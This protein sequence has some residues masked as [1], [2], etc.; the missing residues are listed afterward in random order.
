MDVF[1]LAWSDGG[2]LRGCEISRSL[3][4]SSALPARDFKICSESFLKP[5]LVRK[6]IESFAAEL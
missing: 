6:E 3:V 4:R 1:V 2:D 5:A